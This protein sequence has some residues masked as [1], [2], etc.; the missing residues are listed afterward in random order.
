MKKSSRT[1]VSSQRARRSVLS[2]KAERR[3][4][5]TAFVREHPFA[6][7]VLTTARSPQGG[8]PD[9]AEKPWAPYRGL[10]FLQGQENVGWIDFLPLGEDQP[11]GMGARPLRG[12]SGWLRQGTPGERSPGVGGP[13]RPGARRP[14]SP[15]IW[16][17]ALGFRLSGPRPVSQ[18]PGGGTRGRTCR[19][20]LVV[21]GASPRTRSGP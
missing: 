5:A 15:W 17:C 12:R 20:R 11:G 8:D 9:G 16:P 6:S 1:R 10:D 2:A 21:A 19:W 4:G 7:G 3:R 13:M 14:M 18:S